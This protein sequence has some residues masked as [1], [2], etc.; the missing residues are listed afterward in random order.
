[1][2][3]VRWGAGVSTEGGMKAVIAALLANL[4]IALSK[5]VAFAFTGSSALGI[6]LM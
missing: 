1:M 3:R 5:F 2:E 6:A 4:G